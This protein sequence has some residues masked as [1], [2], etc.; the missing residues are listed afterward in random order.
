MKRVKCY[1][2]FDITPTGIT[3]QRR[4]NSWPV[5]GKN[6]QVFEN[7]RAL[8]YARNQQRN[9]DTITQLISLRTQPFNLTEPI[10]TQS[11]DP[12]NLGFEIVEPVNVWEF[13]FEIEHSE[14]WRKEEDDF[15]ELRKD[16]QGVPMIVGLEESDNIGTLL[17]T[18]G[19]V[20][21]I[22]YNALN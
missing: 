20:R 4:N 5:T 10:Q 16:T 22:V 15:F 7:E 6:G 13:E 17:E 3:T 8:H 18:Q 21:N 14:Q 9:W 19:P 11:M 1:C 2:L 12:K